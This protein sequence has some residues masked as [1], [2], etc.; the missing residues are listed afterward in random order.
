MAT[1]WTKHHNKEYY[2]GA[3]GAM[4]YGI[5]KIDGVTYGFDEVTGVKIYGEKYIEK[6]WRYFDT[7]TGKMA[8]GWS[9]HNGHKYYYNSDGSMYYGAKQMTANGTILLKKLAL[10]QQ[11]MHIMTANIIITTVMVQDI[12][13]KKL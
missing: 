5:E 12:M 6:A 11:D 4:Y 8:T 1:G 10:W 7:K 9:T 3:D 13:V 2:Y